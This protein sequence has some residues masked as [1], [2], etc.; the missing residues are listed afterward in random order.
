MSNAARLH[1]VPYLLYVT[2]N[3]AYGYRTTLVLNS[4]PV[5]S[6]Y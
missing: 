3:S 6:I 2:Y 1:T 5:L 4:L